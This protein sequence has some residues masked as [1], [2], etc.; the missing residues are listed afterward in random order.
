MDWLSTG[1]VTMDPTYL[2]YAATTPMRGEVRDDMNAYLS[3]SFGNPSSIHHWGRVA[4]GAL[5]QARDDVAQA[6]GAHSSEIS[7]VRGGTESDNMAILGWCR[8]QKL[9]GQTPS[10]VVT[11]VEHQAVL[12]AAMS[13][14]A[15]GEALV[16]RI[17]VSVEAG[18]DLDTIRKSTS[19]GPAIVSVMWVNNETG[20]ILPV[21]NV[22]NA[23]DGTKGILHSDAAQAIG[24]VPVNVCDT[25]V[26]LLSATGHKI[27]G[28]KGTGI[29]FI[30]DGVTVAPLIHGGGQERGLRPGTQDVAGAVGFATA[31][32]L[33]IKEQEPEAVR[34]KRL[35]NRMELALSKQLTGVRINGCEWARAPHILSI[36][37]TGI[38]D[39]NQ[40]LVAL[41][42]EGIAVSGGSACSSGARKSSHVIAA[43]YGTDDPHATVRFSFGHGTTD[44]D[45]DHAVTAT[46]SVVERLRVAV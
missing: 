17:E 26:D 43:L 1:N 14:E 4:E 39:G 19:P 35:R 45:V 44:Q 2:D 28:P 32:K 5:E 16:T 8:A 37:V 29:L 3:K 27:Y 42:L 30:R 33:A 24:K 13:A 40:L 22:A 25:S 21:R 12:E 9:E 15:L 18:I 31:M 10:I 38:D 6:L 11:A 41:D 46:I 7:F 36:G 20:L 23:L 34:L